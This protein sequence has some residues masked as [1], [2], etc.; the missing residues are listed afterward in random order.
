MPGP[1]PEGWEQPA[2]AT[3]RPATIPIN[4]RFIFYSFGQIEQL[5]VTQT[6][7]RRIDDGQVLVINQ[8][9][10]PEFCLLAVWQFE[11]LSRSITVQE[12]S[13]VKSAVI[14]LLFDP[15]IA[16]NMRY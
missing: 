13:R 2:V 9:P 12:R 16:Q 8:T 7:K 4:V 1:G 15:L 14:R 5:E 11:H 3:R 6:V 10:K